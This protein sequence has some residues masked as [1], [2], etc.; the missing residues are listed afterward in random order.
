[1]V[2]LGAFVLRLMHLPKFVFVF[3]ITAFTILVVDRGTVI[4]VRDIFSRGGSRD[5]EQ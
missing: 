1:M 2:A 5:P 4:I 3:K